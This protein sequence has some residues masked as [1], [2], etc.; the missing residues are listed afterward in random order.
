MFEQWESRGCHFLLMY[1]FKELIC[2]S[3]SSDNLHIKHS[4][5]IQMC[6]MQFFIGWFT[7][8]KWTT[9]PYE[10]KITHF[11]GAFV[12]TKKHLLALAWLYVCSSVCTYQRNFQWADFREIWYWGFCKY[13]LR[14]SK[15]QL[16]SN[17]NIWDLIW[18]PKYV[19]LLSVTY[20]YL[21]T[22]FL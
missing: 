10:A 6:V 22:A 4:I 14:K 8:Y 1:F 21:I 7:F 5:A 18:R 3:T 19:V 15:T 20:I 17:K 13:L 9:F 2:W 11:L 16:K 12:V